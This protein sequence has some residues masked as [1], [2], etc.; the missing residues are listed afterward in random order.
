MPILHVEVVGPLADDV[1]RGLAQRIAD[2]AGRALDS[3][4]QGTWVKLHL[5]DE[6][7][8][9]ENAGGPPRGAQPVIV[10][11]LQADLPPQ[12][13]L[14]QQAS[15]L[16]EAI[17]GACRRPAENVHVIFEPPAAGRI[18]FGGKLRT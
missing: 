15:R 8:Y 11:V 5:L 6:Q 4:P 18:A 13:T 1:A 17:A 9:A 12:S 3:R 2:A 16:T 10:S 7:A 14:A